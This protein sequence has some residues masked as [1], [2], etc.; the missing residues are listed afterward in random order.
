ML[1]ATRFV[2]VGNHIQHDLTVA[3]SRRNVSASDL[4]ELACMS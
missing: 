1:E 4:A 3:H 2:S